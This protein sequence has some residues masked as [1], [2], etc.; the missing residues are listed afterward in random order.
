MKKP[1]GKPQRS[2]TEKP[3]GSAPEA[4]RRS[5]LDRM[6]FSIVTFGWAKECVAD[7][8]GQ[9]SRYQA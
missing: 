7:Y 3:Q 5:P 2:L 6:F 8:I 4:A 1:K 9:V